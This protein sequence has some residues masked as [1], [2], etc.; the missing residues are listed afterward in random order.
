MNRE[1]SQDSGIEDKNVA[2]NLQFMRMAIQKTRRDI[3]PE[4][5]AMIVWGIVNIVMYWSIYYLVMQELYK[6]IFPMM[7]PLL[8][9]GICVTIFSGIR[10]SKRQKKAGYVPHLSQVIGYIWMIVLAHGAAWSAFGLF[11]DFFGGPGFLW[12]MVYSIGLAMMGI[13]YSK[14]WLW[15]GV[16]IFAGMVTALIFKN[17]AY[18]I[19]GLSRGL[20]CIVP[21]IF[22]QRHYLMQRK[23]ENEN[24]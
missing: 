10:V 19:L 7:V 12:A 21:A 16:G 13:V 1:H 2:E 18:L 17:Y 23:Q 9:I 3:D 4:A 22:A 6:W 5:P 15:G 20:G 14:E 11:Y 24:V 8:S